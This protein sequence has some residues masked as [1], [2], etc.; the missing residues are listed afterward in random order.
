MTRYKFI[1]DIT[2]DRVAKDQLFDILKNDR[3]L[4]LEILGLIMQISDEDPSFRKKTESKVL[5]H[6]HING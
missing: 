4:M 2:T 6:F 5:R 3:S 1:R